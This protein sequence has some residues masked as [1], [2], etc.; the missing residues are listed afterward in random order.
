MWGVFPSWQNL[1]P[2]CY[3]YAKYIEVFFFSSQWP[4]MNPAKIFLFGPLTTFYWSPQAYHLLADYLAGYATAVIVWNPFLFSALVWSKP[5]QEPL[6]VLVSQ[7]ISRPLLS[8]LVSAFTSLNVHIRTH[9]NVTLFFSPILF[10]LRLNFPTA[11]PLITEKLTAIIAACPSERSALFVN[12]CTRVKVNRLASALYHWY[13][14]LPENRLQRTLC[15]FGSW[16]KHSA[17]FGLGP[18][19]KSFH[20]TCPQFSHLNRIRIYVF[21]NPFQYI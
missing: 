8:E 16:I 6:C 19:D 17:F 12:S 7:T 21:T 9:L 20:E 5:C 18:A 1:Q 15:I 13:R 2:S 14:F 11:W 3:L 4:V 10:S